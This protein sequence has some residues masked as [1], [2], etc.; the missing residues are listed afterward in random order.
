MVMIREWRHTRMLLRAGRGHDPLGVSGTRAGKLA[1]QCC[2]CPQPGINLPPLW[3]LARNEERWLY[4]L[5]LSQDANF[6]QKGRTRPNDARD[7][8]FGDG[9]G[10]FVNSVD[11]ANYL[12]TQVHSEE[13]CT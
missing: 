2:A 5:L 10:T 4:N 11:Y 12:S 13:V 8:P 6:K 1:I 9:W 3:Q 7:P